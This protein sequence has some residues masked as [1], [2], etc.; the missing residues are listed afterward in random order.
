MADLLDQL[1]E[2]LEEMKTRESLEQFLRRVL[3]EQK[4]T[5]VDDKGIEYTFDGHEPR[6]ESKDFCFSSERYGVSQ[7]SYD[8]IRYW[9]IKK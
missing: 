9:R 6:H 2:K 1:T 8:Q 4:V 3:T 5:L 7:F